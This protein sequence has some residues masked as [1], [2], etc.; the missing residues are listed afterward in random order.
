METINFIRE[1]WATDPVPIILAGVFL[2]WLWNTEPDTILW[3]A[4]IGGI[5]W[6]LA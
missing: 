6:W 1:A 3:T 2:V 4:V 5:W